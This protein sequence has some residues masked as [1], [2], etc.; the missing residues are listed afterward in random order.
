MEDIL[1]WKDMFV[2][3]FD[4]NGF[5]QE[6][7]E[8]AYRLEMELRGF[9]DFDGVIPLCLSLQNIER[10]ESKIDY[11]W[12]SISMEAVCPQCANVSDHFVGDFYDKL[13]QDIPQSEKA[14]FHSLHLKRY[15]CHNENCTTGKF[16]ERLYE[17]TD[18]QARKTIRFKKYCVERSLGCGCSE[19]EREIRSEGGIVSNDSIGRYLKEKSSEVIEAT[20]IANNVKVLAIDDINLRK[21]DKSSACTV[22]VDQ[23]TGKI[24]II[25]RGT[26]K[27][28]VKKVI[29]LFPSSEF[30]S[31]DRATSYASAGID[32]GKIQVADRFHLIKNAQT[33][34]KDVLMANIPANI[35]IR[36]G[37]GWVQIGKESE[38]GG[39]TYP[40]V[41]EQTIEER[42]KLAGLDQ[43]KAQKYRETIKLIELSGKGLRT[44]DI[45]K[46]IGI[47]YNNVQALRRT[48]VSTI[49]DVE[50][51]INKRI[52]K[53]GKSEEITFQSP[54]ENAIKTV[55]GA[56]VH[57]SK[58][59]IVEPYRETVIK[60][61]QDG[62]SHRTIYPILQSEGYTGSQNAIYQYILKLGKEF[63]DEMR[64]ECKQKTSSNDSV[65]NFDL[66]QAENRPELS[67]ESVARNSVYKAIL[68][69]A[70]S[71]RKEEKKAASDEFTRDESPPKNTTTSKGGSR[72]Q[73]SKTS[74]L[75]DEVIDLIYGKEIS[76]E[77]KKKQ[78]KGRVLLRK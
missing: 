20:L 65:D 11:Y 67:I 55:G 68:K 22:F 23:E 59:S 50:D 44:A 13:V 17:F 10:T 37:D 33:A 71:Q 24:L 64:R 34:V 25:I 78:K 43:K 76:E 48:A 45:A 58:E 21:G 7:I 19:A 61:W 57:S 15:Y 8:L 27:E 62:G 30:L 1:N 26:T 9:F 32:L 47:P 4:S 42:I 69:E 63:P 12:E 56:R 60:M 14:V 5:E 6:S 28:A 72:P 31:R 41:P 53:H 35:F 29:E 54:G 70:S 38:L 74:P 3:K 2:A 46:E 16:I 77:N 49:T 40:H 39:N 52:K 73:S 18:E 75:K 66:S 51:R 36:N